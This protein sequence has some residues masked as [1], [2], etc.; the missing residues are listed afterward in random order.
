METGTGAQRRMW[1]HGD[2]HGGAEWQRVWG[3]RDRHGV[4]SGDGCRGVQADV[5][6]GD[7]HGGIETGGSL[8]LTSQPARLA[9]SV[10]NPASKNNVESN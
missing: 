1:R 7:R 4:L 5:G 8:E 10:R 3:C 2:R 9:E 6:G